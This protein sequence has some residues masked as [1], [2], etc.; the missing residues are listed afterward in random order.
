[1][2]TRLEVDGFKNLLGLKLDL[3]AFTCIA[4]TNGTGK[5]DVFDAVQFL[6]LLAGT[7]MLDNVV[8]LVAPDDLLFADTAMRR[9]PDGSLAPG[10][11]L[12]PLAGS[13]HDKSTDVPPVTRTDIL[14][15]LT[16]PPGRSSAWRPRDGPDPLPG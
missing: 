8:Q 16:E 13:W 6:S 2:L 7:S 1:M 9:A 10:L 12:R 4:G 15:Y 14:P 5:S 3:G 11:Q